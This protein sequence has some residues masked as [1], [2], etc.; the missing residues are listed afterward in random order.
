MK[1]EALTDNCLDRD[2]VADEEIQ[3]SMM[4]MSLARS[5]KI[6]EGDFSEVYNKSELDMIRE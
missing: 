3:R 5:K 4:D 2:S 6:D 1:T